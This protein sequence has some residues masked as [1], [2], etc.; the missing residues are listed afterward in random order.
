MLLSPEFLADDKP[1]SQ[2]SY[3]LELNKRIIPIWMCSLAESEKAG[4]INDESGKTGSGKAESR[5][6]ESRKNINCLSPSHL[7]PELHLLQAV[8]L[9]RQLNP[10]DWCLK[11][12]DLLKQIRHDA[13]YVETHKILL[14]L[15]L[16]WQRQHQ[17]PC[18]LLRGHTLRHAETWLQTAERRDRRPPTALQRQFIQASLQQP[19]IQALDVFLSYSRTD[20][21][22]ARKLNDA[23]QKQGKRTWFD[24]ESIA[25]GA[26]FQQEIYRGIEASDNILFVLS[27]ASIDSPYC[28]DEVDYAASLNKRF[29]TILCREID[30]STLHPTLAKVQWIDFS[31]PNT[32]FSVR[33]NQLVRTLDTDRAYVQSH[34]QYS[35]RAIAWDNQRRSQD[36]LLRGAELA[37]AE[38]WYHQSIE[39]QKQPPLTGIQKRFIAASRR[40]A[41]AEATQEKK[42]F[43]IMQRQFKATVVASIFAIGGLV[44]IGS[45]GWLSFR[46]GQKA[47][48]SLAT[49]LSHQISVHIQQKIETDIDRRFSFSRSV[50]IASK[51]G[52][53]D[54]TNTDSLRNYIW[55]YFQLSDGAVSKIYVGTEAGE[56]VFLAT[57]GDQVIMSIVNEETDFQR[58][59]YDVDILGHFTTLRSVTSY[60]P[61]VRTWYKGALEGLIAS[62]VYPFKL[63]G[64]LGV[65]FSEM[66][67]DEAGVL[68]GVASVDLSLTKLQTVLENI[69]LDTRSHIYIVEPSGALLASTSNSPLVVSE[70]DT[71]VRVNALDSESVIIRQTTQQLI[72]SF[73]SLDRIHSPQTMMIDIDDDKL[74]AWVDTLGGNLGLNWLIVTLIPQSEVMKEINTNARRTALLF[75]SSIVMSG[76]LGVYVYKT[77]Q[78]SSNFEN[79][80]KKRLAMRVL[81]RVTTITGLSK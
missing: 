40:Q 31:H 38:H 5:K 53:L 20:A 81:T 75:C 11:T 14:T 27:P 70:D 61:R 62:P 59:T 69:E 26:D 74:I 66:V 17:N 23:L 29:V 45:I 65:S 67:K 73:H 22:M 76:I 10:D 78:L 58:L 25:P 3:A 77:I 55:G 15:A 33:F 34:T 39:E 41:N 7:P 28:A 21:D 32:D 48:T 24:Q 2:L 64:E 6:A 42:R 37:I 8:D 49:E 1:Q 13:A 9:R 12:S 50:A 54:I 57:D 56:F 46:H 19:P 44:A 52:S 35:Q 80:N 43:S 71:L 60:D 68:Q 63:T 79:D 51:N 47:V 30:V 16:K 36:L 18:I 4:A 72:N